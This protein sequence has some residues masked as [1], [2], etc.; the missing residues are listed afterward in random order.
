MDVSEG[1]HVFDDE[2]FVLDGSLESLF[3]VP[4][5]SVRRS[6]SRTCAWDLQVMLK[7]YRRVGHSYDQQAT[8]TANTGS[9]L[10]YDGSCSTRA[11]QRITPHPKT[12]KLT[13]QQ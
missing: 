6:Q 3:S 5:K 10:L 8:V 7:R 11:L 9:L 1:A 13:P 2:A 12:E 4:W